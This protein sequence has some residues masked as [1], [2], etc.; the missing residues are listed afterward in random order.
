ML[1][2][3]PFLSF[4]H[5]LQAIV[6][7]SRN[8]QETRYLSGVISSYFHHPGKGTGRHSGSAWLTTLFFEGERTYG[9]DRGRDDAHVEHAVLAFLQGTCGNGDQVG[10]FAV[11]VA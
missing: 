10:A 8:Q 1:F 5:P 7:V 4:F 2:R 11:L 3:C 6:L 9:Y